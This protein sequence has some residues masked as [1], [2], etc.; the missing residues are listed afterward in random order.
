[1]KEM[2]LDRLKSLWEV[3]PVTL[4]TTS[5]GILL[6]VFMLLIGFWA[7]LFLILTGFAGFVIGRWL[8]ADPSRLNGFIEKIDDVFRR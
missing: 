5:V 6:G 2:I 1:M 4:V 8:E 3:H 7:T